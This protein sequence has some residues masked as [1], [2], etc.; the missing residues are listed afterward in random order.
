MQVTVNYRYFLYYNPSQAMFKTIYYI[1]STSSK[2]FDVHA[3]GFAFRD[4]LD[5]SSSRL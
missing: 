4:E 2:Q 3:M 1:T 5:G